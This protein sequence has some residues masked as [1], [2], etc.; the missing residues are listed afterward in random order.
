MNTLS[1][2]KS[3]HILC[4]VLLVASVFCTSGCFTNKHV[5]GD[6]AQTSAT[7]TARQWYALWGLVP[8]TD[9]DTQAMAGDTDDYTVV[10]QQKFLDLVI[11]A[12]TG[13]VTVYPRSVTVKK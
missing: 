6:G 4:S 13:V 12:F 7:E 11:G 9:V 10:T 3:L 5:V 8:V 1:T 2:N